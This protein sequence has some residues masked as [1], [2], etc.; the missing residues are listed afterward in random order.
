[1]NLKIRLGIKMLAN[2]SANAT[3]VM[4]VDTRCH[5][6]DV[7]HRI[8]A[9]NVV[10]VNNRSTSIFAPCL[11]VDRTVR[12]GCSNLSHVCLVRVYCGYL[13]LISSVG[14]HLLDS[15]RD[16]SVLD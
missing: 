9:G 10:S 5:D 15:F 4:Q 13:L 1:M 14:L 6:V 3:G 8:C 2:S 11:S 7:C 16:F 12:I